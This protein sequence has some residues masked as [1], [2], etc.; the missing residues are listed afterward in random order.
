MDGNG[1]DV[2][3][4]KLAS[5]A[6]RRSLVRGM[7]GGAVALVATK[8]GTSQAAGTV[9]ICH[10]PP[11]NRANA[12]VLSVGA[13]AVAAHIANHGDTV[14]GTVASCS[15]CRDVCQAVDACT[16]AS[17][18]AGACR[19]TSACTGYE[20]C[21]GGGVANACGCTAEDPEVT[22]TGHCGPTT[23]NCGVTVECA[24]CCDPTC[25][26]GACGAAEDDGCGNTIDCSGNCGVDEYCGFEEQCYDSCLYRCGVI[27]QNDRD[28][29]ACP[30]GQFC[31]SQQ[32]CCPGTGLGT[33]ENC[34]YCGDNCLTSGLVCNGSQCVAPTGT[35]P[36][37]GE[38]QVD[39]DCASGVCG[40]NAPPGL[41]E[42]FCRESTCLA[43]GADCSGGNGAV[44]CCSGD[45][46]G[47]F[48]AGT[49]IANVCDPPCGP[50]LNCA[51]GSIC[52]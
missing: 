19:S 43:E 39:A 26:V 24:P 50:G 44:S 17:C 31:T 2:L 23:N 30:D 13:N 11:G 48:G 8:V 9:T 40:C 7:I 16:P 32:Y 36:D 49:C 21:G 18:D 15:S 10:Y 22:C 45:C 27:E 6:S 51:F 34:A 46:A 14:L 38:C 35:V 25:P 29:G 20:T 41:P 1:F 42:C 28:C 3:T 47:P 37:S 4:R 5:G 52:Q 33:D 12:Q